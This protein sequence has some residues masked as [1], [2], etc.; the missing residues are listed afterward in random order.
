[1]NRPCCV[2]RPSREQTRLLL[3]WGSRELL[4]AALPPPGVAHPRAASTLL[5]GLSL[6]TGHPLCVV[7]CADARGNSSAL[8]LCDGFGFGND[9][10]H[11]SVEVVEPGRKQGM[12]TFRDLR[13]MNLRGLG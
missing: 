1:M 4:R 11:Y 7:L 13:Q 10:V 6:W 9:C 2:I 3:R 8:G 12:G 5:E